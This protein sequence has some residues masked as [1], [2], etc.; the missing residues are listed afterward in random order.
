MARSAP[1]SASVTGS[2][3]P[4]GAALVVQAVV[5]AEQRQDRARRRAVELDQEG[6]ELV[7]DDRAETVVRAGAV[8]RPLYPLAR[9]RETRA[10]TTSGS[11]SFRDL[12]RSSRRWRGRSLR[13]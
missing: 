1:L 12:A 3:P 8:M 5:G 9:L 7:D 10:S 13:L 6:V 4:F 11:V 2:K